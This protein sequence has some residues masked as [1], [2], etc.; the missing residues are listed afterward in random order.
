MKCPH[1]AIS[2]HEAWEIRQFM[3]FNIEVPWL[4]RTNQC[5]SCKQ[6]ILEISPSTN[7]GLYWTC[8]YPNQTSRGPVPPEVPPSVAADFIEADRVLPISPKASAAL[9]RR[10]LQAVLRSN[11][12]RG[13]DLSAEIDLLLNEPDPAKGIPNS[14]RETVDAIRIFGNFSAHPVDDR[15][16]LQ[17]IDVEPEEAE[18]CLEILEAMFE[19]FY[20]KPAQAAARKAALNKKLAS[21]GKPAA[22]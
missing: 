7:V 12:Y 10:C 1:C 19:H 22:K 18:W 14:L 16:T 9:S 21:A 13:R 4:Y 6:W 11:G 15:T 17:I 3:R 2:I 8:I 5:P 20:V